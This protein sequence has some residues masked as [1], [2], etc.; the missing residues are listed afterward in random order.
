MERHRRVPSGSAFASTT[1]R[2]RHCRIECQGCRAAAEVEIEHFLP[3]TLRLRCLSC[4]DHRVRVTTVKRP[5]RDDG[6][7]SRL[8]GP[9]TEEWRL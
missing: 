7:S 5:T 8:R 4:D 3:A 9:Q 6:F 1:T 2:R